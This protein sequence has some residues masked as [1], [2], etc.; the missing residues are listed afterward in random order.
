MSVCLSVCWY[1]MLEMYV[2]VRMLINT[3]QVQQCVK[4][5]KV[6]FSRLA[7]IHHPKSTSYQGWPYWMCSYC[8]YHFILLNCIKY[9]CAFFFYLIYT[10]K[11]DN[12]CRQVTCAVCN[13]TRHT[14]FVQS[15]RVIES[16][17]T[18]VQLCLYVRPSVRLS[19]FWLCLTPRKR[20]YYTIGE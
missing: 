10:S 4:K 1:A 11:K 17:H 5:K 20:I 14:R 15:A 12:S 8:W 3:S 7:L 13:N 18:S 6:L 9:V 19:I 2:T 16:T